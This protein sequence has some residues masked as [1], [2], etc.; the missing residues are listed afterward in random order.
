MT[1]STSSSDDRSTVAWRTWGTAA[2]AEAARTSRPVL[3]NLTAFWGE[4]CRTMEDATYADPEI[5]ALLETSLIPLRVDGDRAPH[6]QDRYIAGGWPT[7][8]FLTPTGEVLWAGT[9]M[10]AAQ[11]RAVAESVLGAWRD[12]REEL[13][14]EI[15]RRRFAVE[16]G[17]GRNSAGIVR[18]ERADDVLTAAQQSFDVRNGG[19]GDAP[20][21]PLPE[22]IELLYAHGRDDADCT[23]MADRTLD[24]MLAGELWD[25]EHGG[26]FHYAVAADWTVPRREKLL[27]VNAGM[28]EACALGAVVRNR[29]DCRERAARIVGWADA[30]LAQGGLWSASLRAPGEDASVATDADPTIITSV[31]ARW[32]HALARAG[33]RLGE[34]AWVATAETAL[35]TLLARMSTAAGVCHYCEE[36]GDPELPALMIDTLEC[37]RAAVM[38]AQAS[39][40]G[41]WLDVARSLAQRMETH[42]W[43]DDGG[44]SDRVR[45]DYDI[46]M[47]RYHDRPFE[48]N[49]AAAGLL[50]DLSHVTGDRHWRALAERTLAS[51]GAVAGRH[52]TTAGTFALATEAFFEAPSTVFIALPAGGTADDAAEL[53]HRAFALPVPSLRVWTVPSGHAAGPQR[54][55]ARDAPAA[56]V[57]TRR[58]CAGP[59]T[60]DSLSTQSGLV[61]S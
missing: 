1:D 7:T 48:L 8:A 19:F 57:L 55:V 45:G 15:E 47:L 40:D 46:G 29:A 37:A 32:V 14:R 6:V 10:D 39:G 4:G 20:K 49:A 59:F 54:F 13:E 60:T 21:F 17:R 61:A 50:L 53:R 44:F 11:L 58:G 43:T 23:M 51:I 31:N 42:F 25:E 38:L 3:L 2:F 28:L 27:E 9:Y 5:V 16:A 12:R 30:K 26:F 52:G 36:G 24:G 35:R 56:W 41:S 33:A 34:P 18:R 22:L